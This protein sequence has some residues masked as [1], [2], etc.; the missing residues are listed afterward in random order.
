[1]L[2]RPLLDNFVAQR[3]YMSPP[4][5]SEQEAVA[6][7]LGLSN[8]DK[9]GQFKQAV[10]KVPAAQGARKGAIHIFLLCCSYVLCFCAR[11]CVLLHVRHFACAIAN[12]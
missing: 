4:D 9:P 5:V 6:G 2:I 11:F 1:M 10:K 8:D 3:K 12:V 7:L